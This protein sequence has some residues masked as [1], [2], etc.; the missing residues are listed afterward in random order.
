MRG[1]VSLEVQV[2]EREFG[3]LVASKPIKTA[4]GLSPKFQLEHGLHTH[5]AMHTI[6][7][8]DGTITEHKAGTPF[9]LH[10]WV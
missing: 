4:W 7:A 6:E 8:S 10:T 3:E 9:Q 5:K 1:P 2:D